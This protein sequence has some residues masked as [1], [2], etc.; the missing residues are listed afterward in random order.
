MTLWRK[1]MATNSEMFPIE[2]CFDWFLLATGRGALLALAVLTLQTVFGSKLRALWRYALWFPVLFVL[3]SPV[4]PE[5]PFSLERSWSQTGPKRIEVAVP[6]ARSDFRIAPVVPVAASSGTNSNGG[7]VAASVWAAGVFVCLLVGGFAWWRALAVFRRGTTS[8]TP[9]L[10]MEIVEAARHSGLRTT[11]E[12]LVSHTVPGPAMSGVLRPLLLLPA[13]FTETFGRDE[14]RLILLHEMTHVKRGDLLG[15]AVVC[16]LQAI[17]WCNPLVWLAF[18]R[19]RADRELACDSAV[20]SAVEEDRRRVYGQALLKMETATLLSPFRLGFVG[21]VGLFERGQDLRSRLSA[22]AAHR[23]NDLASTVGGLVLLFGLVFAGATRAQHEAD[24]DPGRSILI[25]AK[26]IEVPAAAVVARTSQSLGLDQKTG[27]M[28]WPSD[29]DAIDELVRTPGADVM[30]TP[31]VVTSSGQ[32][33]TIEIGQQVPNGAGGLRSVGIHFAVLPVW[34][35]G[36]I[37]MELELRLTSRKPGADPVFAERKIQSKVVVRPGEVLVAGELGREEGAGRL[38]LVL[39]PHLAESDEAERRRRDAILIPEV[40]FMEARLSEVLGF[41]RARSQQ[42]DPEKK[43]V[44]LVYRPV[45]GEPEPV[46]TLDLKNVPLSRVIRYLADTS[47]LEVEMV[48]ADVVLRPRMA[49]RQGAGMH[50]GFVE[51]KDSG[52]PLAV[53][54]QTDRVDLAG[55]AAKTKTAELAGR[56]V[57][58]RVEFQ[59]ATLAEVI[60]FLQA[61]S[62]ELD[63]E[64]Q[65][66]NFV[67]KIPGA[68]APEAMLITLSLREVPLSEALGHVAQLSG[69]KLRFE[70][71][72]VVLSRDE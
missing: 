41:L 10:G 55:G 31:R 21:L 26:F 70:E 64:R 65:G 11:P 63:P 44:N 62:V 28:V 37:Q 43:G 68:P 3:G 18:A 50:S 57:L 15:N 27:I 58:P 35:D 33:A 20:L 71:K 24:I 52:P 9:E 49:I 12:V 67:L 47:N 7:R 40:V 45:K 17:H 54:V 25:E 59:N 39:R 8:L 32:K 14:R 6:P 22:I 56:F 42:L 5:S 38:F 19:F 13:S 66:L 53:Q 51:G 72:A 16:V 61:K 23:G 36:Q 46:V 29:T 1:E 34:R 48:D 2:A 30:S 60:Q 69:L 4:L